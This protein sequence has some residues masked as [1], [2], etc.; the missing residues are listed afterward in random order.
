MDI[1]LFPENN[2]LFNEIGIEISNALFDLYIWNEGERLRDF[3]SHGCVE[4]V[5][6]ENATQIILIALGCCIF[7]DMNNNNEKFYFDKLPK[8]F[9]IS[10]NYLKN[11]KSQ[12]HPRNILERRMVQVFDK[13]TQFEKYVEKSQ[14]IDIKLD[15]ELELNLEFQKEIF[16]L[17]DAIEKHD[18][19]LIDSLYPVNMTE[20]ELNKFVIIKNVMIQVEEMMQFLESQFDELLIKVSDRSA[21]KRHRKHFKFLHTNLHLFFKMMKIF[22][23][24]SI[25]DVKEN[26]NEHVSLLEVSSSMQSILNK[27]EYQKS[28][29]SNLFIK[30]TNPSSLCLFHL[31]QEFDDRHVVTENSKKI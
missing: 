15:V 23:N 26:F 17:S 29:E 12:Y 18:L 22:V 20:R 25:L 11:Y 5:S 8:L 10:F 31:Q 13:L 14:N 19:K 16:Q 4:S 27:M 21:W 3:L 7:Y 2:N 1:L 9:Q 30:F 28:F 24:F 6:K